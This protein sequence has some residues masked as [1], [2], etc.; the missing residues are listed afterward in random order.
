RVRQ[1][2]GSVDGAVERVRGAALLDDP[3]VDQARGDFDPRVVRGGDGIARLVRPARG[4]RVDVRGAARAR[5][6]GGELE[7]H[8]ST[9]RER[10]R[11]V[12]VALAALVVE[13]AELVA[14]DVAAR[15]GDVG[16]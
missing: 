16:G 5:D 15:D 3:E 14:G 11:P 12:D 13:V 1:R 8:G 7:A 10:V 9:R 2:H 6:L 4:H